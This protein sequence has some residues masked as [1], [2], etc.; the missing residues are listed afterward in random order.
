[1]IFVYSSRK[2]EQDLPACVSRQI[3]ENRKVFLHDPIFYSIKTRSMVIRIS[4]FICFICSFIRLRK[5]SR[6]F[7]ILLYD[8]YNIN[9]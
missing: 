3:G 8:T 6:E 7:L 4:L 2:R 1:M 5:I 9:G